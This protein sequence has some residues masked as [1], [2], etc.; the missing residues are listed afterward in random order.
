MQSQDDPNKFIFYELY[1]DEEAVAHHTEQPYFKDMIAFFD[2]GGAIVVV[3]KA[4]GKFMTW[5]DNG[6]GILTIQFSC[7]DLE[8]TLVTRY[9]K[10]D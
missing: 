2:W 7:S 9:H 6:F 4:V 1:T 8:A 10:K 5:Y 3:K